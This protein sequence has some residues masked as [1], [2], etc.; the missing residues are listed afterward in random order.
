MIQVD[1][2]PQTLPAELLLKFN[3]WHALATHAQAKIGNTAAN[4]NNKIWGW[5]KEFLLENV[6]YGKCAY[7]EFKFEAGFVGDAEHYRPKAG[8]KEDPSHPG[9]YW[10]CY[11]WTN[12]VPSCSRCN[13]FDGKGT[14]FPI[15]GVRV[16]PASGQAT[17]DFSTLQAQER[18]L[19]LHPYP[20]DPSKHLAFLPDGSVKGITDR[21]IMSIK[22][23]DLDREGLR[24]ARRA[25]MGTACSEF[26]NRLSEVVRNNEAGTP[27]KVAIDALEADVTS[28][29]ISCSAA[30]KTRIR[31]LREDVA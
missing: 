4:F 6:F 10:L 2:D 29:S 30:A 8:V 13:T 19:L 22:V 31:L 28:P 27:T 23:Y 15:A 26:L 7:C 16:G 24:D 17:L 1:F 18:P 11:D 20:D 14:Q 3:K 9:Y 25:A 5:L 21:G 12:L